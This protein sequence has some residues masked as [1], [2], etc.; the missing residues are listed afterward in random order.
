M[1][2]LR[3]LA[4]VPLLTFAGLAASAVPSLAAAP[5]VVTGTAS[6]IT[7]TSAVLNGMVTPDAMNNT[8]FFFNYGTT[9]AYGLSTAVTQ[10]AP[11]A[12]PVNEAVGVSGLTP[13]TVY[14]FQLVA[15]S[16]GMPVAGAD[17]TFTTL[18]SG[19]TPTPTV[20]V[21]PTA[22]PT[23]TTASVAA[24]TVALVNFARAHDVTMTT[25]IAF[26][27]AAVLAACQGLTTAQLQTAAANAIF[28][29]GVTPTPARTVTVPGNTV[30]QQTPVQVAV[31]QQ[32]VVPVGA[33]G[34]GGGTGPETGI[35]AMAVIGGLALAGG[36]ALLVSRLRRRP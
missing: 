7:S 19:A 35:I 5:V 34:T 15:T 16:V 2:I 27:E 10:V 29:L 22:T 4:V 23:V 33:P 14:H 28:D 12:V 6:G 9:A 11:S 1:K 25:T 18:V 30:T 8:T 13:N 17:S 3:W 36:S 32:V 21:T 20:T 31:P 26:N 24:C